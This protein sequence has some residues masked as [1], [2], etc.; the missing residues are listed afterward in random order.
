[1]FMFV[2]G[3]CQSVGCTVEGSHPHDLIDKIN[4]GELEMPDVSTTWSKFSGEWFLAFWVSQKQ[5]HCCNH[6]IQYR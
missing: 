4:A 3:T 2:T 5:H 6:K 1:M